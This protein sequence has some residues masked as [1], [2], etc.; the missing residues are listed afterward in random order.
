M[1]AKTPALEEVFQAVVREAAQLTSATR[2]TL[3]LYD[4]E[5]GVLVPR[6]QVGHDWEIYQKIRLQPGEDMSGQVFATG[7]PYAFHGTTYTL[8]PS[9]RPATMELFRAAVQGKKLAEERRCRC[10]CTT[11]SSALSP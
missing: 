6:A 5:A 7:E 1:V 11:R 8:L 10:A 9:V 3:F 4:E 2:T